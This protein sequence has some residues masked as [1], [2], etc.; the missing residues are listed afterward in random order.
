MHI[1]NLTLKTNYQGKACDFSIA[2]RSLSV[3]LKKAIKLA[4][5]FAKQYFGKVDLEPK[6]ILFR[7]FSNF[8]PFLSGQKSNSYLHLHCLCWLQLFENN[9]RIENAVEVTL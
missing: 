5:F 9:A 1:S 2:G 8:R 6:F 4:I 3:E 7:I